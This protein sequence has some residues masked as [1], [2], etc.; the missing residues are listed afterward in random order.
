MIEPDELG[1]QGK[2]YVGETVDIEYHSGKDLTLSLRHHL[3]QIEENITSHGILKH[4]RPL[5]RDGIPVL[6]CTMVYIVD[7]E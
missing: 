3:R 7:R 6:R 2:L 1:R 5:L 4:V